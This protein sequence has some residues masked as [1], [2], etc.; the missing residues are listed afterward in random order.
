MA[1]K[2]PSN[3][4][5][6]AKLLSSFDALDDQRAA[7]LNELKTLHGVRNAAAARE[8]E[9]LTQKYGGDD[10]R[11]TKIETRIAFNQKFATNLDAEIER[12]KITTPEYDVNTW[13]VHG[14]VVDTNGNAKPGV[15]LSLSDANGVWVRELGY[16]CSDARGYYALKSTSTEG[17]VPPVPE[18][19]PL[20]VTATDSAFNVLHRDE[21][22]VYLKYGQIDVRQLVL[23]DAQAPC[24]P[25]GPGGG[26]TT[27]L[28]P[29]AW[30]VRGRVQYADGQPAVGLVVSV[31]D[32]DLLFDDRLGTTQTDGDGNFRMIYRTEAFLDL[33]E[34]APDLYVKVLDSTGT[35]LYTTRKAVRGEAGRVEDFQITLKRTGGGKRS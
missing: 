6:I 20:Y 8:K 28:P 19:Q 2:R 11:V 35:V 15:T 31:Y 29:D 34:S 9:R 10:P 33:F 17:G 26:G 13:M 21:R 27:G 16:T 24:T 3:E 23:P 1:T 30:V 7:G 14:R 5:A 4:E 22:A 18:T 25:P 32:K 12:T